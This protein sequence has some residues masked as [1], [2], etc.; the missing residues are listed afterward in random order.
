MR[1][2][3]SPQSVFR[4]L[5]ENG[6]P[7]GFTL[8]ELLVAVTMTA[9]IT[10]AVYGTYRSIVSVADIH[11]KRVRYL[12]T[13]AGCI[14]RMRADMQGLAVHMREEFVPAAKGKPADPLM[15]LI[16]P[17]D[18]TIGANDSKPFLRMTSRSVIPV[19]PQDPP[20]IADIRYEL[21]PDRNGSWDI[22]RAQRLLPVSE[23]SEQA[24][25]PELHPIVCSAVRSV[26]V[27]AVNGK[28]ERMQRWDSNASDNR[29]ET[30]EAVFLSLEVGEAGNRVDVETLIPLPVRR[31][32]G[33]QE[34][35]NSP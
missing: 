35:P 24:E 21:T 2:V 32:R 20:G 16:Q 18:E 31:S 29:Y 3:R 12:E 19:S 23:R 28:G 10:L 25:Q 15:L 26:H 13:A 4:A 34:N 30:P 22:R 6:K 1:Q 5:A 33:P 14:E 8:L 9:V 27:A 17:T 7:S 11:E